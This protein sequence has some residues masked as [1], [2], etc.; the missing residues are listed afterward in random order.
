MDG[1]DQLEMYLKET[2]GI[3]GNNTRTYA[4]G[5]VDEGYETPELFA[6]LSLKELAEDFGFKKGHVR[7]VQL[8]RETAVVAPPKRPQQGSPEEQSTAEQSARMVEPAADS[9]KGPA[10]TPAFEP[11]AVQ[12]SGSELS[13]SLLTSL[14]HKTDNAPVTPLVDLLRNADVRATFRRWCFHYLSRTMFP[15]LTHRRMYTPPVLAVV[16]ALRHPQRARVR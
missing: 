2:V 7:Q 5:L 3:P 15:L 4:A 16:E 6:S 11:A 14:P 8:F 9:A 13:S 12:G 1:V 10:P